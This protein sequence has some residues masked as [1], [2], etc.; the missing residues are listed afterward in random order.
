MFVGTTGV[1]RVVER[2]A[3]LMKEHDTDEVFPHG[4]IPLSVIQKYLNFHF[5]VS[6]DLFGS[7]TSTNAANYFSGGLKGRWME[8]RRKDDHR[9]LDAVA[10]VGTVRDGRPAADE[11]PALSALNLDLRNEYVVD[12]EHGVRRW[13]R[14]LE[15]AGLPQRLRLPHEG[16][17]RRVGGYAGFHLSPDGE[18]LDEATWRA[19]EQLWLPSSR[20]M[21]NVAALMRPVY[22]PGAFASWINPP[23]V[24]INNQSVEFGYVR[25]G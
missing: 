16:F 10:E 8:T 24:G 5:A 18:I 19:R 12:C 4:G 14:A 3:A 21:E 6:M 25:I 22:D 23:N 17:N 15:G 2:T 1:Q 20:D 9:L 7:E 13:N 11:V